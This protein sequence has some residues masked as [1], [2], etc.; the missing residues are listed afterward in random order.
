VKT[1]TFYS[2]VGSAVTQSIATLQK[3]KKL[4][5][6]T[7][8]KATTRLIIEGTRVYP[9]RRMQMFCVT[10]GTRRPANKTK[11]K[12]T[13]DAK[14]MSWN[15]PPEMDCTTPTNLWMIFLKSA[16]RMRAHNEMMLTMTH[17]LPNDE[18]ENTTTNQ[19][20]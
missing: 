17:Q 11:E 14:N 4:K 18:T 3:R 15:N 10:E 1:N 12:E 9:L 6:R 8:N 16:L 2:P 13:L 20:Q 19:K 7:S 5:H